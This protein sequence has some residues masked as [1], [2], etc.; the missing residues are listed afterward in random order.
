MAI[1]PSFLPPCPWPAVAFLLPFLHV[2]GPQW[3]SVATCVLPARVC[4]ARWC[5]APA[6]VRR[7]PPCSARARAVWLCVSRFFSPVVITSAN[8]APDS[9]P[10][11]SQNHLRG[12]LCQLGNGRSKTMVCAPTVPCTA[13]LLCPDRAATDV[14]PDRAACCG[15]GWGRPQRA[16]GAACDARAWLPVH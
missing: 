11:K 10:S 9:G 4:S 6:S 3:P 13:V 7:G 2:R 8:N 14:C 5:L 16:R 1:L 15:L 12:W